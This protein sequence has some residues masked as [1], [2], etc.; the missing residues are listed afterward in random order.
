MKD[1]S[2]EQAG[3]QLRCFTRRGQAHTRQVKQGGDYATLTRSLEGPETEHLR[4]LRS[5][6]SRAQSPAEYS[7]L[8]GIGKK[9]TVA[10]ITG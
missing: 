6:F 7:L 5:T 9:L 3:K 2:T 8:Y 4:R 1:R 10:A